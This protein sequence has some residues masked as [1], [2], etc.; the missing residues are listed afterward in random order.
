MASKIFNKFK[1]PKSTEFSKKDLVIDVKEGH[2]YYKSN[3]GVH[4]LVGDTV[5]TILNEGGTGLWEDFGTFI[6]HDGNI[7]SS[8][9]LTLAGNSPSIQVIDRPVLDTIISS[10]SE[11]DFIIELTHDGNASSSFG[12]KINFGIN[13]LEISSSSPPFLYPKNTQL[14]TMGSFDNATG[15]NVNQINTKGRTFQIYSD[16]TFGLGRSSTSGSVGPGFGFNFNDVVFEFDPLAQDQQLDFGKFFIGDSRDRLEATSSAGFLNKFGS[17]NKDKARKF[18]VSDGGYYTM[19]IKNK[20]TSFGTTND[21]HGLR[22]K[23]NVDSRFPGVP[24]A[25][26]FI[27]FENDFNDGIVNSTYIQGSIRGRGRNNRG[28]SYNSASDKRLKHSIND[29]KYGI[30]DLLKIKVR[31]YKWINSD[32]LYNGFIAQELNEIYPQAVE[33]TDNG[34]N[35]LKKDD[36]PWMV[37]YSKITPLLVK[38]VQDQ[39]KIIEELKLEIKKLKDK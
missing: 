23:L 4:K 13:D 29:T 19:L 25:R 34:L 12:P 27:L 30:K 33:A 8:G 17:S 16:P 5:N 36:L 21:G 37:D 10:S 1:E 3:I 39:Q 26:N 28:V 20:N 7:S 9:N 22:I 32:K 18:N 15:K 38:S 2:L 31:D 11:R 24:V 14:M 6:Y 35:D